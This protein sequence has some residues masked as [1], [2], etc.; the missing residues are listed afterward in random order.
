MVGLYSGTSDARVY[1]AFSLVPWHG[2][3]QMRVLHPRSFHDEL[4]TMVNT[5]PKLWKNMYNIS[6][7]LDRLCIER[8][9]RRLPDDKIHTFEFKYLVRYEDWSFSQNYP[10]MDSSNAD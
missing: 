7:L 8:T 9:G 3:L 10:L 5:N 1:V 6:S 2:A 4:T